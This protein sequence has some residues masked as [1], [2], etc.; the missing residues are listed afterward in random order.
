MGFCLHAAPIRGLALA[1]PPRRKRPE[2]APGIRLCRAPF[3]RLSYAGG[4]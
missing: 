2:W 3:V 1:E 4:M